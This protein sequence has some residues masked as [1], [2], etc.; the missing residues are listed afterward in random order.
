MG[1]GSMT[2]TDV[3]IL[4]ACAAALALMTTVL[5]S[6]RRLGRSLAETHARQLRQL[7]GA[8]GASR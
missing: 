2:P 7:V 1:P 4:L 6:V 3:V 8:G 5:V